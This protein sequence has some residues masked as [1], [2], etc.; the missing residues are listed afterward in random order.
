MLAADDCGMFRFESRTPKPPS[1]CTAL[2]LQNVVAFRK[3]E[4][5]AYWVQGHTGRNK[6]AVGTIVDVLKEPVSPRVLCGH[7]EIADSLK[8]KFSLSGNRGSILNV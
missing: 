1:F 7:A 5:Q 4:Y 3:Q 6:M 8:I 2:C